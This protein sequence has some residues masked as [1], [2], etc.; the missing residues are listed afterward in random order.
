MPEKAA[1]P[2]SVRIALILEP[3]PDNG[4]PP[5]EVRVRKAL[6]GLLRAHG[7]KNVLFVSP[8]TLESNPAAWR[9][10]E[11]VPGADASVDEPPF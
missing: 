8:E 5:W 4:G 3:L 6:K 11:P 9:A 2:G 1:V 7:L 10:V